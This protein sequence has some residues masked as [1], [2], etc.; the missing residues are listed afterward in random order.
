[1]AFF[2]EKK[3][4]KAFTTERGSLRQHPTGSKSFLVLFLEKERLA[5]LSRQE[6]ARYMSST[7]I[8]PW[9]RRV[10]QLVSIGLGAGAAPVAPGTAGSLVGLA[11]GALLL[12]AS[13]AL[14]LIGV[15]LAAYGGLWAIHAATGLPVRATDAASHA[16]P[17]WIVIDEVAGQMLAMIVLHRPS[18][19][20]LACAFALFRLF[21]IWKPGP[22]GWADR[23][24]GAAGVMADDLLAGL[25][26]ALVLLA[27]QA[28]LA[29]PL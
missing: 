13:P 29:T 27:L 21:D 26:A 23:Q 2:F 24:G 20:G 3:K 4:Q 19:A 11:L 17:G 14:L 9:Q 7:T 8:K 22:I 15:V 12:A 10:G 16:D 28:V 1:M 25:A 18:L 6:N 5:L